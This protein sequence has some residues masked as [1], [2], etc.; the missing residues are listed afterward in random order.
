MLFMLIR[1]WKINIEYMKKSK[2]EDVS[3]Y[4]NPNALDSNKTL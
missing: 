3:C 2:K 4:K 1:Y